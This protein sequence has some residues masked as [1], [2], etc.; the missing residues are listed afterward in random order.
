MPGGH[1]EVVDGTR[2]CTYHADHA[3]EIRLDDLS[4]ILDEQQG[5]HTY[6]DWWKN[7]YEQCLSA[8]ARGERAGPCAHNAEYNVLTDEGSARPSGTASTTCSRASGAW[9]G[10]GSCS[11]KSTPT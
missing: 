9:T 2:H 8:V 1:C 5:V 11:G 3:G 7:S 10:C 6:E 4:G